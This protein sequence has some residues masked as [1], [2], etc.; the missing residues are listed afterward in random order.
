MN[1][2]LRKY[3]NT[4][5]EK[6][7]TV[8]HADDHALFRAGVRNAFLQRTDIEFIGEAGNG[9]E[10]LKLLET[11]MP[12]IVILNIQMPVMD[13]IQTLPEIK[14][15]YPDLRVIILSMHN[16]RE[17]VIKLMQLGANSYLT[18]NEN[19]ETIHKAIKCVFEYG[20]YYSKAIEGA[21]LG[22]DLKS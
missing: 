22:A 8:I 20:Y 4:P 13:G 14:K 7:I 17:M 5:K 9:L 1:H 15:R 12:D 6:K 18:K 11:D 2:F 16:N 19:S 21:F 10:L 3:F